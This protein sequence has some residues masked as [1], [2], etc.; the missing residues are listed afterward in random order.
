[1]PEP[2]RADLDGDFNSSVFP[3]SIRQ[4]GAKDN[5]DSFLAAE[6]L[7]LTMGSQE[8]EQLLAPAPA[9]S[10]HHRVS[11]LINEGDQEDAETSDR[12]ILA[13]R[14]RDQLERSDI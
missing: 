1:M 14:L 3:D 5:K 10:G 7:A 2:A 4:A 9:T 6:E 13:Q 11:E 12:E 8:L